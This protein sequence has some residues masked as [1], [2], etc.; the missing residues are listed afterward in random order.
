MSRFSWFFLFGVILD[1]FLYIMTIPFTGLRILFQSYREC[2]LVLFCLS[3]H[4]TVSRQFGSGWK[5]RPTFCDCGSNITKPM[6]TVAKAYLGPVSCVVP[7]S[8]QAETWAVVC[9]GDPNLGVSPPF[10]RHFLELPLTTVS[11][12][13]SS[14]RGHS[15]LILWEGCLGFHFP[16]LSYNLLTLT[17]P[18]GSSSEKR[19][20]KWMMI[21]SMFLGPQFLRPEIRVPFPWG[22]GAWP[23]LPLL[24]HAGLPRDWG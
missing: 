10:W 22:L 7:P 6:G 1:C 8:G 18:M 9:A 20:G 21:L 3:R 24:Q 19:E 5:S 14:S 13:F 23:A 16:S 2:W 15:L 11:L 17:L 4:S 12:T